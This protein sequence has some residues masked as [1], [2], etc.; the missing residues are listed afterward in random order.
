MYANISKFVFYLLSTTISEV[1]PRRAAPRRGRRH[2]AA[3]AQVLVIL[4][5]TAF[6]GLKS[7][8]EPVQILW[9]NLVCAVH[10]TARCS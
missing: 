9:L 10:A 5:C 3:A 8:L 7:P 4:I 1:A 6:L 2:A